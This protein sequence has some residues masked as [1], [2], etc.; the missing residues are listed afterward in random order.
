MIWLS[1]SKHVILVVH[2]CLKKESSQS[3][4]QVETLE[5]AKPQWVVVVMVTSCFHMPLYTRRLS[6]KYNILLNS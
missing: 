6:K 5:L 1:C 3:I 2:G 4:V